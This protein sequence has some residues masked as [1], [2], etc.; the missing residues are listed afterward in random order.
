MDQR[1]LINL[2]LPIEQP[3]PAYA[4]VAL[5]TVPRSSRLL[6]NNLTVL[7]Y[8]NGRSIHT[9]RLS[10]VIGG[11]SEGLTHTRRNALWFLRAGR[12]FHGFLSSN[13]GGLPEL[14]YTVQESAKGR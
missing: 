4:V 2:I 9:G 7:P 5:R 11:S 3:A 8:I 13:C 14:S 10:G 6:G 1:L 12:R